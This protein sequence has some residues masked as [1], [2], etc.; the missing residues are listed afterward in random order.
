MNEK[1]RHF[2]EEVGMLFDQLGMTRMSGRAF[3]YLIVCDRD[4]A[5]F[6]QIREALQASKGSISPTMKQLVQT[7]LV[8]SVSLPGDRK[9]YFR[10]SEME[11]GKMLEARMQ[12]MNEFSDTL[13]K[14]KKMK[15][16]SDH[17]TNWLDETAAFYNW[18]EEKMHEIFEE[19]EE[20]KESIMKEYGDRQ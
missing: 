19:W 10:I 4:H 12:L 13:I 8:E 18:M 1:K 16:R 11:I 7:G 17:V 6:D 2:L 9:T 3:A 20:N 15:E 5:S 14:G